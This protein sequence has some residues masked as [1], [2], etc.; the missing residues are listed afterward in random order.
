[1]WI[2]LIIKLDTIVMLHCSMFIS[3]TL[4]YVN[5]IDIIRLAYVFFIYFRIQMLI[6]SWGFKGSITSRTQCSGQQ[7]LYNVLIHFVASWHVLSVITWIWSPCYC[8][9]IYHARTLYMVCDGKRKWCINMSSMVILA[10]LLQNA[11]IKP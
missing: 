6:R 5:T 4:I 3:F 10:C 1:M 2:N 8:F 7:S 11:I 9:G